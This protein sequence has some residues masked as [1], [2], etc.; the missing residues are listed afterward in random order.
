MA[1]KRMIELLDLL[2]K[3][4]MDSTILFGGKVVVFGG[5]VRQTLP[6]V[7]NEEKEDFINESL[8][9]SHILEELERLRLFE[10]MRAKDDPSFCNYLLRVGNGKEKVTSTNKIEIPASFIV[11]YTTEKESLDKLFAITYPD[12]HIF[13]SSSSCTSSRVI[14][15]T[16]NDFVDDINDMLVARF[17]EEAKTF[18]GIDE[19]IEPTNQSQ[20]EDLLHSLNPPDC[21]EQME[22]RLTIDKITPQT[23]EWISKVQVIEKPRP[24][25]S[26]DG[27]SRFQIAVQDEN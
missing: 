14:L 4:L 17:L 24:R 8:L 20:Y 13:F 26:K 19:T 5:D 9:Y 25:K 2:L 10:N 6:V 7:R 3:D 15:T 16:K 27:K 22:Y 1:K 21:I 12:L 23:K 11:P 18:V